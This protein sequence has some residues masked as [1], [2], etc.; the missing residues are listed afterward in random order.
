MN[1]QT[2]YMG[3]KRPPNALNDCFPILASGERRGRGAQPMYCLY[4]GSTEVRKV[5]L[6]DLGKVCTCA[7]CTLKC[8]GS[9]SQLEIEAREVLLLQLDVQ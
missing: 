3:I 5:R 1:R 4:E 9:V 8:I 7:I 6:F 2:V